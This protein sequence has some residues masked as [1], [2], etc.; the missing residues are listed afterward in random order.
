MEKVEE[1]RKGKQK[2]PLMWGIVAMGRW[3]E[4]N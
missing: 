4:I 3:L 2:T 1:W